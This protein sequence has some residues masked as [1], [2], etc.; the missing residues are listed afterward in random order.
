MQKGLASSMKR[1][2]WGLCLPANESSN[3][4]RVI[5]G[6]GMAFMNA[7]IPTQKHLWDCLW[8]VRTRLGAEDTESNIR[9]GF[10]QEEAY[11]PLPL[12]QVL[13][14][15]LRS[16]AGPGVDTVGAPPRSP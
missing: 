7:F 8:W 6:P 5:P 10:H 16:F 9:H 15:S 2:Y 3:F 13:P 12:L 14:S 1:Y 4:L 11:C